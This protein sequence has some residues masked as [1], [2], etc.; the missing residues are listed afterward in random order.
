MS[1]HNDDGNPVGYEMVAIKRRWV[2]EWLF[3]LFVY[4]YRFVESDLAKHPW[5]RSLLLTEHFHQHDIG[6]IRYG[7]RCR[8]P[9]PAAELSAR[10]VQCSSCS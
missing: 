7:D 8:C 4:G 3:A 2:P 5:M 10:A 9:Q 6:R 1:E